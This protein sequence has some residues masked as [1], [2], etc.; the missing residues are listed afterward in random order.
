MLIRYKYIGRFAALVDISAAI[1]P[2][3]IPVTYVIKSNSAICF[4]PKSLEI[5]NKYK[6]AIEAEITT[7]KISFIV[8]NVFNNAVFMPRNII[9]KILL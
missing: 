7:F 4:L 5:I 1:E 9:K 2:M 8:I 6:K 3:D